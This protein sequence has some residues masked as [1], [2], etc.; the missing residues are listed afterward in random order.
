MTPPE[1]VQVE[2]VQRF[3]K[4]TVVVDA[5]QWDGTVEGARRIEDWSGFTVTI[6]TGDFN[7][8]LGWDNASGQ[9]RSASKGYW[10]ILGAE[11]E[12]EYS[13]LG[14][15]QFEATYEPVPDSPDVVEGEEQVG[16]GGDLAAALANF[17][18][19]WW[20]THGATEEPGEADRLCT[21]LN[22]CS[23]IADGRASDV[24]KEVFSALE[25][26][27]DWPAALQLVAAST[28]QAVPSTPVSFDAK[29]TFR[30]IDL[31]LDAALHP[32]PAQEPDTYL[33]KIRELI[34][35]FTSRGLAHT[36]ESKGASAASSS[37]ATNPKEER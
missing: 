28:Q 6:R 12:G 19:D 30:Q 13:A 26:D 1:K 14:A 11:V 4:K 34:Y 24:Q 31:I 20:Q 17:V 23:A 9:P 25:P 33:R 22:V 2:G 37:T 5:V 27:P 15:E 3:R 7:N 21:V 29:E 36:S 18:L 32:E 8:Y 16:A 10:I 35:D